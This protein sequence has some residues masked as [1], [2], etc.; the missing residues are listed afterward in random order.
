[1]DESIGLVRSV[2]NRREPPAT[3]ILGSEATARKL[4]DELLHKEQPESIRVVQ[5]AELVGLV[6]VELIGLP[7]VWRPI[8]S[9]T[10]S[11]QQVPE[12]VVRMRLNGP[13]LRDRRVR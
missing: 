12:T 6:F 3:L 13:I 7:Q 9:L 1:M 5:Y 4:C 10:A 2:V 8:M 11:L